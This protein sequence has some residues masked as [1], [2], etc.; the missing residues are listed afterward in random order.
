MHRWIGTIAAVAALWAVGSAP[1]AAAT[2][3]IMGTATGSVTAH[4]NGQAYYGPSA[5]ELTTYGPDLQVQLD[6]IS[7]L[8]MTSFGGETTTAAATW[9]VGGFMLNTQGDPAAMVGTMGLGASD[10]WLHLMFY[11]GLTS[12]YVGTSGLAG[13]PAAGMMQIAMSGLVR[14]TDN[15]AVIFAAVDN[16][17]GGVPF[18]DQQVAIGLYSPDGIVATPIPAAAP[19][20]AAGIAGLAWLRRRNRQTA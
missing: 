9:N 2:V 12:S 10:G 5:L 17:D 20:L 1:A 18:N 19:L 3:K 6:G 11:D 7:V 4:N 15:L 16:G 13:G 14:I 8:G